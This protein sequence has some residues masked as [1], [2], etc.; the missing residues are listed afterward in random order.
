VARTWEEMAAAIQEI[1]DDMIAELET[2]PRDEFSVQRLVQLS[3]V[4][5]SHIALNRDRP[6]DSSGD[7]DWSEQVKK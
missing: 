5:K 6:D 3:G 1:A 2:G 7:I 4:V